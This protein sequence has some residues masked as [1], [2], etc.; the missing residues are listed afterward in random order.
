MLCILKGKATIPVNDSLFYDKV[1]RRV[2]VKLIEF[3]DRMCHARERSL[4]GSLLT[5]KT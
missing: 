5:C 3:N 4:V 1:Y 2:L